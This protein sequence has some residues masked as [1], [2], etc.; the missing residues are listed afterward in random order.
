MSPEIYG[1]SLL[2]SHQGRLS[3]SIEVLYIPSFSFTILNICSL[4]FLEIYK[5]LTF[6]INDY[7]ELFFINFAKYAKGASYILHVI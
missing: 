7:V 2:L 1:N 5:L 6:Y 4:L 3:L